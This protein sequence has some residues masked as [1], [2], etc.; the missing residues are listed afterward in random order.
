[1]KV[2]RMKADGKGGGKEVKSVL[3]ARS[4]GAKRAKR[5]VSF[6]KLPQVIGIAAAMD[7]KEESLSEFMLLPASPAAAALCLPEDE[8][9]EKNM[10]ALQR[11]NAALKK[12]VK[13]LLDRLDQLGRAKQQSVVE[14]DRLRQLLVR[15]ASMSHRSTPWE[16]KVPSQVALLPTWLFTPQTRTDP[17][18]PETNLAANSLPTALHHTQL[19]HSSPSA[20]LSSSS[21]ESLAQGISREL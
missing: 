15:Q 4:G 13:L 7:R 20:L 9:A 14:C 2:E 21:L 3:K 1:M 19:P 18:R 16:E 12:Y 5:S 6:G 17:T 8:M 11:Q 10:A